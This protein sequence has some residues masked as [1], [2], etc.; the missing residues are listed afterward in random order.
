MP[1][2]FDNLKLPFEFPSL[3]ERIDE[4]VPAF[5]E[6]VAAAK[7]RLLELAS[8]SGAGSE[9][10]CERALDTFD[11]I[12]RG[13]ALTVSIVSHLESVVTSDQVRAANEKIQELNAEWVA[14]LYA[15]P[16]LYRY[17]S[18]LKPSVSDERTHK[19]LLFAF[20]SSGAKLDAEKR[21]RFIKIEQEL[22]ELTT[23]F[24]QAVVDSTKA[25]SWTAADRSELPGLLE[26]D[27]EAAS[28]AA[29]AGGK[30]GY[31]FTLQAPSYRAIAS[32]HRDAKVREKFVRAYARRASA[33]PYDNAPIIERVLALRAERAQLLGYSNF[34]DSVVVDRMAKHSARIREF[35]DSLAE[36][37]ARCAKRDVE[38]LTA[39]AHCGGH[40]KELKLE[41]WDVPFWMQR[42]EEQELGLN[43]EEIREYFPFERTLEAIFSLLE[44]VF[45]VAFKPQELSVWWS[46]VQSFAAQSK[47]KMLGTL[48]TDYYARDNK[49]A[50]AWMD[51]LLSARLDG[52]DGVGLM[53][54][55]FSKPAAGK[56]ALLTH[57][58]ITTLFHEAGHLL[59]GLV[60]RTRR[61]QE[62]MLNVA[63]DFVEVPSQ[64]L[65]NWAWE[66]VVL[67]RITSHYKTGAPMPEH[68]I[69]K[70]VRS[71]HVLNG[72]FYA[73]H[74]ANSACDLE[75][76]TSYSP[77]VHGDAV[78]WSREFIR[79]FV[80]FTLD[81]SAMLNSFTH[82]FSEPEGYAGGY[83]SYLW[84]EAL[85]ADIFSAFEGE[86]VL[87]RRVGE[88][89]VEQVLMPGDSVDAL[90]LFRN[91]MG[92][93]PNP[94]ALLRRIDG[95]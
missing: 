9:S 84:S 75:L 33:P 32:F 61:A 53:A 38:T 25:W 64:L 30:E 63:W 3:I 66:P 34:V 49:R 65:E 87:D 86:S 39:F 43:P 36:S 19:S 8:A 70:L 60:C 48:Y 90:E 2:V 76:H 42:Y 92:R 72:I 41:A 83:Y 14:S 6:K 79:R 77:K 94:A 80:P 78:T 47:G 17:F 7:L 29:K 44:S 95:R 93:D 57:D 35:F 54:G 23:K 27:L 21:Q 52:T 88:R 69:E 15:D 1:N 10:D 31:L 50:G 58:E 45:G 46:G 56:P 91:F 89:F 81:D 28:D 37:V 12:T 59:H 13:I 24:S 68:L 22:S 55:N 85:E 16:E 51:M 18:K 62:G 40:P 26:S 4:A 5:E 73:R 11:E 67:R 71:R 74:L 20:E 82:L